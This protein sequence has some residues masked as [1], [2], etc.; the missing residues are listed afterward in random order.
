MFQTGQV[1]PHCFVG[2]ALLCAGHGDTPGAS[3]YW[4]RTGKIRTMLFIRYD[5]NIDVNHVANSAQLSSFSPHPIPYHTP[6][7]P[8]SIPYTQHNVSFSFPSAPCILPST[9]KLPD[10]QSQVQ[11]HLP[12]LLRC[13][14]HIVSR[15]IFIT[16]ITIFP[17]QALTLLLQRL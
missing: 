1:L 13:S 14:I 12:I 7:H 9:A 2:N 5:N 8:I 6:D 10:T 11:K 17:T 16:Q 3:G 4:I 15:T